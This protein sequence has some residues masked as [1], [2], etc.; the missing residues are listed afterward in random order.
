M[1]SANKLL[2]K[3]NDH[4]I[5]E[6]VLSQMSNSKV[7]DIL[8]VTG[9]ER[10]RIEAV[11][12]NQLTE[13]IRFV[14]NGFYYR[15]R[16]ESI[17]SAVRQISENVEAALFMVADKPGI[18]SSLMDRAIFKFEKERPDILYVETPAGRGHPIIFSKMLFDELLSMDGDCVGDELIGGHRDSTIRLKDKTEQIDVDN[19]D[20]YCLLMNSIAGRKRKM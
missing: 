9:F 2:L 5:I 19:E 8:V 14:Y 18:T 7:D 6:E 15:G 1:G 17:K 11:L 13:R 12:S 10:D 20:D 3:Y 16:A 4:T